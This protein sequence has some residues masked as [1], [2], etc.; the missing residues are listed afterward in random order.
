MIQCKSSG[1]P[2]TPEDGRRILVDR[3]WPQDCPK[4]SLRLDDWLP[5]VAPSVDLHEAF[6]AGQLDFAQF[7]AAYRQELTAHPAHWW[8]LLPYAETAP[9]TLVFTAK[10]PL[11]NHAIVL[12]QWLEDELDRYGGSSSPVCYRDEFPDD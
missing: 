12:V 11:Q 3:L 6:A 5:D 10:D 7:T 1:D 8:A 2:A 4:D 9:L